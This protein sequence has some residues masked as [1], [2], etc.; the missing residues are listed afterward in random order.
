[1]TKHEALKQIQKIGVEE[2]Y[3]NNDYAGKDPDIILPPFKWSVYFAMQIIQAVYA[4]G[5]EVDSMSSCR[6]ETMDDGIQIALKRKDGIYIRFVAGDA[7]NNQ[8]KEYGD[9]SAHGFCI[10][11]SR[12]DRR[13]SR[14]AGEEIDMVNG[15]MIW[16]I[17]ESPIERMKHIIHC[18]QNAEIPEPQDKPMWVS[19]VKEDEVGQNFLELAERKK[20]V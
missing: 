13:A 17:G 16:E 8:W 5:E 1:M 12:S 19:I 6:T 11:W 9:D 4:L 18:A 15:S 10:S 3:D 20:R 2:P 14:K 7:I